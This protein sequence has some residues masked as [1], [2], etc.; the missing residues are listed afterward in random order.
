MP[1]LETRAGRREEAERLRRAGRDH[2]GRSSTAQKLGTSLR[3]AGEFTPRPEHI[4]DRHEIHQE[5]E[6]YETP[7]EPDTPYSRSQ[8]YT[9]EIYAN[10]APEGVEYK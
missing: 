2:K 5:V 7:P 9:D 1:H 6:R 3:N 8:G 10:D 4:P